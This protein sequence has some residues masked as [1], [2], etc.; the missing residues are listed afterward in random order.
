MRNLFT[1]STNGI[2]VNNIFCFHINKLIKLVDLAQ[3]G[4]LQII[5]K[6]NIWRFGLKV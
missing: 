6:R 1:N 2:K 5:L 4:L 3:D